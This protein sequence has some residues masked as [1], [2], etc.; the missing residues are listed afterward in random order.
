MR[1]IL[2]VMARKDDKVRIRDITV[3]L[4]AIADL[5]PRLPNEERRELLD[6]LIALLEYLQLHHAAEQADAFTQIE[7]ELAAA[8]KQSPPKARRSHPG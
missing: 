8:F 2:A 5:T 4:R 7:M 6:T 3:V 1:D